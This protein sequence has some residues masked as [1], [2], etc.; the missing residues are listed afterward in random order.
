MLTEK[1]IPKY[2]KGV[3]ELFSTLPKQIEELKRSAAR[4]GAMAALSRALA[5]APELTAEEMMDGFPSK[6][7]DGSEF[8]E[9]DYAKCMKASRVLAST[10]VDELDL[11]TYQAAYSETSKRVRGPTFETRDLTPAR[12]KH[13]FA[14]EIDPSPL[15]EEAQFEALTNCNWDV[16]NLQIEEVEDPAQDDPPSS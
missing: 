8:T 4:K 1:S 15:F 10:L 3:I 2:M 6:K 12:R 16:D 9:A 13:L 7:D 14:P 11:S 5:F